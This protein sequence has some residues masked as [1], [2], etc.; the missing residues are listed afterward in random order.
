MT[1]LRR[2]R[3]VVVSIEGLDAKGS[4]VGRADDPEGTEVHVVGAFPGELVAARVD[5]SSRHH[6]R[7]FATTR[8]VR[9]AHPERVEP[10]CSRHASRAG[11]CTGCPLM[12]LG[13]EGQREAKAARIRE[14]GL[15]LRG[16]LVG[17]SPWGYRASSK[18]VVGGRPGRLVLGSYVR[19]THD[20]ADMSGCL[21]DHPRIRE[22]ADE[23]A[24]V[25]SELGV[26][27][28]HG[29]WPPEREAAGMDEPR[30]E[31][32]LRYVWLKTDG[33]RVLVTLVTMSDESRVA[34]LAARLTVPAGVAHSVQRTSGN[35]LRGAAP[36]VLRGVGSLGVRMAGRDTEVGPLGFLQPNPEVA[37]QAYLTLTR[38]EAGAPCQGA[39]AYD[40]YAGAGVTTA[41]LR[42]RFAEVLPCEA[43]PESA[44]ALG[45]EPESAEAF[46]CTP[47]MTAS[48]T[49]ARGTTPSA[50]VWP[51]SRVS[52]Q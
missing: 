1:R 51:P 48:P 43:Y 2:G 34:E 16:P 25:G 37:A 29:S 14:L 32:D 5:A 46:L 3:D 22:A 26:V 23:I 38:D 24:R 45:V 10:A 17:G 19:D 42:E 12:A 9:R 6:R 50:S 40:L 11:S 15:D 8:E 39:L 36:T 18:R 52:A 41:L 49:L 31:P 35:T 28:A 33:E 21:V 20:L 47:R 4:G 13:V 27:P 44:R 30:P 7:A